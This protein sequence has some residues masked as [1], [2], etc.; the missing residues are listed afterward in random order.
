MDLSLRLRLSGLMFLQYFVWGAWV[1]ALA[2]FLGKLPTE[3]GLGFPQSYIGLIYATSAIGA[4]I[5]P[6]FIGLFADRLFAT[7]KVLAVLH[8]VGALL[9]GWAAW[10]CYQNQEPIKKTFTTLAQAQ[11]VEGAQDR[12]LM[13]ILSFQKE[14][15]EQLKIAKENDKPAIQEQ[16]KAL[17]EKN[18]AEAVKKVAQNP[19]MEGAISPAYTTLLW[20]M[21]LYALCYMPTLT[22][23]NSISFRNM[24]DPAK[25][26]GGVRVLGSIGW[27]A[28]G[29]IVGFILNAVSTQPLIMAALASV[30]L[31]VLCLALP[32]TPPTRETKSI[33]DT[34]G[35]PAL[36]MLRN[37]SV[38]VCFLCSFL[39]TISLS[40]YFLLGNRFLTDI[41]APYPTAT[42]TL[43]QICETLFMLLLPVGLARLGMRGMLLLGILAW[44]LRD[45]LLATLFEPLVFLGV[46]MHGIGYAFFFTVAYMYVDQQAP[47]HLRASAQGMITFVT[48]GVG[49][50]LGNLLAGKVAEFLTLGDTIRYAPFWVISAGISFVALVLLGVLFRETPPVS[51]ETPLAKEEVKPEIV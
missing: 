10:S 35:V 28:A 11:T 38:L 44:V 12:K 33:G 50:F 49:W 2:T 39:V 5:S 23:S 32:N 40:F 16:L 21:L 26:F 34:L 37:R 9:L 22:L 48:L 24:A 41:H 46:P 25:H 3:G 17:P 45:G 31:G 42:Q 14:L 15:Q 1:V 18:L 7:E 36:A 4:I 13:E 19:E 8:L 30:V 6:L 47:K 27:I 51:S 20:A 43:G 29:W